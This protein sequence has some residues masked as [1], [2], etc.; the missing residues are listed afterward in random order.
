MCR[1]GARACRVTEGVNSPMKN[2][3]WG[4]MGSKFAHLTSS[5]PCY[6]EKAHFTTA[7]IH[8]PVAPKCNIQCNFCSRTMDKCEYRP[9]AYGCLLSPRDA[10]ARVEEAM[11]E[12]PTLSVVGVAGPGEPLFNPETFEAM[13]LVHDAHPQLHLCIA[14][15]GLLLPRKIDELAELGVGSITVTINGIDPA[16]VSQIVS[17]VLYD[18]TVY[19]G[20]ESASILTAQQLAGIEAAYEH[21]IPVK[22][23]TVLVPG[24]NEGE[25]EAIAREA[26][27]RK[28]WIMNIIPLIPVNAFSSRRAPTCDELKEARETAERYL[29]QFRLCRQCRADSVGIPGKEH[30]PRRPTSEYF[31]G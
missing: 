21:E 7:R 30:H 16:V 3:T 27:E 9:G 26:S 8:L 14:S 13:R 11:R 20:E 28:A 23:N 24:I 15:N 12:H 4:R 18:G 2:E 5:H 17:W 25:I 1:L 22:I 29:P 31:H 19:R 10:V 6:S